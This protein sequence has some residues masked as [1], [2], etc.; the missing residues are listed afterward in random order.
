[1]AHELFKHST[2]MMRYISKIFN[3]H[4]KPL[5]Y[6]NSVIELSEIYGY[7]MFFEESIEK[8]I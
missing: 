3:I 4:A 8:L 5:D 7:L 2:Y 6:I 1:M